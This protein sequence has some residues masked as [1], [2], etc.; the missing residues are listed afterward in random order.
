VLQS[1]SK[2]NVFD[3]RLNCSKLVFC[4]RSYTGS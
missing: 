4:C 2:K 1:Q 3:G